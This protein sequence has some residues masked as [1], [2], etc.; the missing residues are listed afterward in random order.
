VFVAPY[1]SAELSSGAA[2]LMIENFEGPYLLFLLVGAEIQ[3]SDT[4]P[5]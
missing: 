1:E 4:Q 2:L 5:V 3:L